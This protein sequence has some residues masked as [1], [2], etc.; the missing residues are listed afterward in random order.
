MLNQSSQVNVPAPSSSHQYKAPEARFGRSQISLDHSH[1]TSFD[2]GALIPYVVQEVI[3]GDTFTC[4]T[5]LFGRVWSA[6]NVPIMDDITMSLDYFFVPTRI[7]WTNFLA[8]LGAHDE[9]GAQDS[10][11]T[12]PR[13]GDGT[14]IAEGTL[15]HYM[16]VPIG[17]S[18]TAE[19]INEL[20]M[21][22]YYMIYN[23]WYRDQNLI[24]E[25]TVTKSNGPIFW[26][27]V[28][29][30][31][32]AKRHD[33]FTSALPYLQKGT[34]VSAGLAGEAYVLGLGPQADV[35]VAN[36][37]PIHY[38]G[39]L[40][41]EETP[42]F[43]FN[44]TVS[45]MIM[46]EDPDNLGYPDLRVDLTSATGV[47]INALR[48][49]AAIQRLLEK[50]A[51]GG[52]RH[53]ELIR[54]H[55]GVDVPDMR[56]QR[57]EYLGGGTGYINVSPVPNASGTGT[58]GA[59]AGTAAGTLRASFAKSFVEHGYIF[60]ILRAR[61][62]VSYSQGLD[63]MWSRSTK[64]DFLWPELSQLGEQPIYNKELFLAGTSA[65][66]NVFG[67]QERYADYRFAKSKITGQFDPNHSASLDI[68]HLSEDFSG[69]PA[70]NSTFIEDAT[71]MAR[72]TTVDTQHDFIVDG[73]VD[74]R[75]ARILPVRPTPTLMPARF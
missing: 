49:A 58:Q 19:H 61:G 56:T 68:W 51:R 53:P 46:A 59:L 48:E 12:I 11:Y 31:T 13:E 8:F 69:A 3:P 30:K 71:P 75:V 38:A 9:A 63:R 17:L 34:E 66:D 1:K 2:A 67:Y 54:A 35:F 18:T 72:I 22:C 41:N 6:L 29:P 44:P 57:P 73:R 50:D 65:D 16:G 27:N 20:P 39:G 28:T 47:T 42:A 5:T 64:Y 62:A 24:D 26:G 33:Y 25:V 55:F 74:M 37:T 45:T 36:A 4:K 10:S 7:T 32:S 40:A 70:L 23:E 14:T 43:A 21:R 52:T 60:G 15:W